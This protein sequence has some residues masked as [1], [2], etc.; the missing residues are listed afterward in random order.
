MKKWRFMRF[1]SLILVLAM[2]IETL[3]VQS[4]A[5]TDD[6]STAVVVEE[7]QPE[8]SVLGEVESLR[9]EDTK[10][11]RLSDGSFVAVSYGQPV[12][13]QSEDGE[14]RDI[15]NSLSLAAGAYRTANANTPAA[16]SST[17]T[18]GKLFSVKHN[19]TSVSM[20]ILDTITAERM[21]SGELDTEATEPEETDPTEATVETIPEEVIPEETLP[22]EAVPAQTEPVEE[23]AEAPTEPVAE[24]VPETGSSEEEIIAD[25]ESDA[26]MEAAVEDILSEDL[27]EN[28]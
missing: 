21:I 28:E 14:W 6:A 23:A 15:D 27:P 5:S 9:E 4:F 16:F 10:H 26:E 25:A 1:L 17:L 8:V 12:H 24:T 13:F 7:G 19:R 3:P 20:S 18:D 11:F 2:L 22:E